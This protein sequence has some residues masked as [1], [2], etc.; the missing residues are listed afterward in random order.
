MD[1]REDAVGS[2]FVR[3]AGSCT[4]PELSEVEVLGGG[5]PTLLHASEFLFIETRLV[6]LRHLLICGDR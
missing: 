3:L 2:P 5:A 4:A 6:S 1:L